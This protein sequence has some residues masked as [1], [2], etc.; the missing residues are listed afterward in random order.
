MPNC[1]TTA[2]QGTPSSTAGLHGKCHVPGGLFLDRPSAEENANDLELRMLDKWQC[3][4]ALGR[5]SCCCCAVRRLP[6]GSTS[7]A[8]LRASELARS[9]LAGVT[10]RTRLLSRLMNCRIMSLIWYSM[11]GGW[12]PTG[13]LVM[14]GRSM[15]V[16]FN[17][18]R[19]TRGKVS[20]PGERRHTQPLQPLSPFPQRPGGQAS[21]FLLQQQLDHHF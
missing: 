11:S 2:S 4:E 10:A 14:P 16:R 19:E 20:E 18:G 17:T 21:A 5:G 1:H 13:T 9:M 3:S 12:S 6:W 7:L 15:R 8:I